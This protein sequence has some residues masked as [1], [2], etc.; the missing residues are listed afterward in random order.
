M[1]RLE[2]AGFPTAGARAL[3]ASLKKLL[4]SLRSRTVHLH[5]RARAKEDRHPY[6]C[7]GLIR[8]VNEFQ[9]RPSMS[10]TQGLTRND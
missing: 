3:L 4:S 2:D 1:T 6:L 10:G 8:P 5:D 9:G 7:G